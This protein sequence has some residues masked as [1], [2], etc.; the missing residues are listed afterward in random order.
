M[1][2]YSE[3]ESFWATP[4]AVALVVLCFYP[5]LVRAAATGRAGA[6]KSVGCKTNLGQTRIGTTQHKFLLDH[7]K[8]Q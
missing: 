7:E 8:L 1:E 5:R 3:Y 4:R 2:N 6:D